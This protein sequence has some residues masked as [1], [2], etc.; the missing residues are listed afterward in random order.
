M[1]N[2]RILNGIFRGQG[3]EPEAV[4]ETNSVATLWAHLR[5]G[6]WSAVMP[7]TY[8]APLRSSP[9]PERHPAG[10]A[11]GDRISSVLPPADRD[12]VLPVTR[13][14]WKSHRP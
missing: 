1:Q 9:G 4:I 13:P 7:Q 11:G 10:R 6:R 14:C 5:L 12:P 8:F 3:V 2:R